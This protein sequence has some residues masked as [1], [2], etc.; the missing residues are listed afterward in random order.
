MIILNIRF[1]NSEQLAYRTSLSLGQNPNLSL[2]YLLK[3]VYDCLQSKDTGILT[4]TGLTLIFV[5][6]AQLGQ[7]ANSCD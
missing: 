6:A 1:G 2:V 5:R 3:T 7:L 4:A